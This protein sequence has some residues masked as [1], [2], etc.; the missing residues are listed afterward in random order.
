MCLLMFVT[1]LAA[2]FWIHYNLPGLNL[3]NVRYTQHIIS[4]LE[5]LGKNSSVYNI[6]DSRYLLTLH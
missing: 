4:R 3:E 6:S 5:E 2:P 1:I